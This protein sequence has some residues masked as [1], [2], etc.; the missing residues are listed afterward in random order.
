MMVRLMGFPTRETNSSQALSSRGP[1]QRQ[2]T[3]C[4]D[5]DEYRV[6]VGRFEVIASP[7]GTV[8]NSLSYSA[9]PTGESPALKYARWDLRSFPPRREWLCNLLLVAFFL[10]LRNAGGE[11]DTS[12]VPDKQYRTVARSR[13]QRI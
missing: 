2:T 11:P 9:C 5:K 7:K 4:K 10:E 8:A 3:S 12:L 1:A 13:L 6:S